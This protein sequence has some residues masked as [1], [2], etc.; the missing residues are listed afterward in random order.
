[1]SQQSYTFNRGSIGIT[2]NK[3]ETLVL[4]VCIYVEVIQG[5]WKIKY[6]NGMCVFYVYVY[7]YIYRYSGCIGTLERDMEATI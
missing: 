4:G 5:E 3:M 7:I 6:F 1:M 2:E